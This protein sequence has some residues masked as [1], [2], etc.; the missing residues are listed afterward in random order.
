[1]D[2]T[3]DAAQ[4]FCPSLDESL[5]PGSISKALKNF[6]TLEQADSRQSP[7]LGSRNLFGQDQVCG[8]NF[9]G[10]GGVTSLVRLAKTRWGYNEVARHRPLLV[11]MCLKALSCFQASSV[12]NALRGYF[13][14]LD[15]VKNH[16][17]EPVQV[18]RAWR[19]PDQVLSSQVTV[20]LVTTEKLFSRFLFS[21][22]T[23][24]LNYADPLLIPVL[25]HLCTG[26]GTAALVQPWAVQQ[27]RLLFLLSVKQEREATT[28]KI[29]LSHLE[30]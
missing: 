12:S 29:T 22:R 15:T 17:V 24:W 26:L 10:F 16:D 13:W 14:S 25:L 28:N 1:M 23:E 18:C 7:V 6:I 4:H 11:R 8:N 9:K 27:L 20:V 5:V 30:L 19:K 3:A 21:P 2:Q